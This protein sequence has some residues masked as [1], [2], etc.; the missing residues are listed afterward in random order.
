MM[1]LETVDQTAQW[2]KTNVGAGMLQTDSRRIKSG[3]AFIAWPGAAT[4]GREYVAAALKAG[5]ACCLV[6]SEGVQAFGFD[7]VRIAQVDGLK[8]ASGWIAAAY[9]EQPS[10]ALDVIAVTGTNGKTSSAWWIAQALNLLRKN[11]HSA[12]YSCG[13]IGTLGM[14]TPGHMALT[15][16]TTPDPVMLQG[17]QHWFG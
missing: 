12:H 2:M 7:D 16:L 4:D 3:D 1:R 9:F 14:G 5:A 13:L 10:K 17:I 11:E 6:E 15:G 8:A